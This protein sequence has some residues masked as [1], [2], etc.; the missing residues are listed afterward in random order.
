MDNNL[1]ENSPLV[2]GEYDISLPDGLCLSDLIDLYSSSNPWDEYSVYS[3]PEM[4]FLEADN[5]EIEDE[6]KTKL[7]EV[8][9]AA[10]ALKAYFAEHSADEISYADFV[11][12]SSLPGV[13]RCHYNH[14]AR[15]NGMPE[16]NSGYG[17]LSPNEMVPAAPP[18]VFDET[19]ASKELLQT[20]KLYK[21]M[22]ET[23]EGL[24]GEVE[25]K[26]FRLHKLAYS[27][28][29][30][31]STSKH[32]LFCGDAGIGKTYTVIR[33]VNDGLK[34]SKVKLELVFDKG[35]A[36][37][38]SITSIIRYFYR[39]REGK[40]V[41]LDDADAVLLIKDQKINNALKA[42]FDTDNSVYTMSPSVNQVLNRFPESVNIIDSSRLNEGIVAFYKG[43]GEKIGEEKISKDDIDFYKSLMK[44]QEANENKKSS[45][46][47][48]LEKFART[49]IIGRVKESD[50]DDDED[51]EQE[52]IDEN[53][54][55]YIG[56]GGQAF[57]MAFEYKSR[58]IFI[59]NLKREM[60]SDAVRS[61]F[62]IEEISLT[63]EEFLTR[64]K[65]I[66]AEWMLIKKEFT[67]M[68][69]L[70][71]LRKQFSDYFVF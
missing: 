37:G 1:K 63:N 53:G 43:S 66:L 6:S 45:K 4:R 62:D 51:Y 25:S 2:S 64:L 5:L 49:G 18:K 59:S 31:K 11:K 14:F 12:S 68:K 26:F 65:S 46:K 47:R 42:F 8:K 23:I 20:L 70:N 58:T 17:S 56:P 30:R 52:E 41:V 38:T 29:A 7:N 24:E 22:E 71:G 54:G 15:M 61:R 19:K 55:D 50:S 21:N 57:P 60:L 9:G 33:A 32:A 13:A 36:T 67:P 35:D 39:N 3:D 48:M 34:N 16:D 28:A 44:I 40:L 69:M 10:S 27:V